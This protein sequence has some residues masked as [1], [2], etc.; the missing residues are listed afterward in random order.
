M[1]PGVAEH[2]QA[3][4]MLTAKAAAAAGLGKLCS[5][6][7]GYDIQTDPALGVVPCRNAGTCGSR[8]VRPEGAGRFSQTCVKN[9]KGTR[10]EVTIRNAN[11]I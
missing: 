10:S 6:G 1:L 11:V 9:C 2:L 7:E 5:L 8:T 4:E 3:R